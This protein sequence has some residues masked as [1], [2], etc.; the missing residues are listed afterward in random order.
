[1]DVTKSDKNEKREYK[2]IGFLT[3]SLGL[4][5][6]ASATIFDLEKYY[7]NWAGVVIILVAVVFRHHFVFCDHLIFVFS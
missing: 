4:L 7:L 1:M 3:L 5:L 2:N 6:F